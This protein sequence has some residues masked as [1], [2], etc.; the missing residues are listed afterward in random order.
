M[1]IALSEFWTRLVR[2]GVADTEDCKQI[3]AAYARSHGGS[4]PEDAVALA[5]FLVHEG[6]LSE[7]QARALLA[8][9]PREIRLG[10]FLKLGDQAPPPLS[11]WVPVRRRGDGAEGWLRRITPEQLVAADAAAI[12]ADASVEA[13]SLQPIQWQPEP[14]GGGLLFS[15]IPAGRVLSA[16]LA[17]HRRLKAERVIDIGI[18]LAEALAALHQ[19]GLVHGQLRADRVWFASQGRAVLLRDPSRRLLSGAEPG[20]LDD[21]EPETHYAAPEIGS[22]GQRHD[23]ATDLYGLGC[24]LFRLRCGRHAFDGRSA[25]EIQAAHRRDVPEELAGAVGQGPAGDPLLRV[26]ASALAKN[27]PARFAD[28]AQLADALRQAR[29]MLAAGGEST[30]EPAGGAGQADGPAAGAKGGAAVESDRQEAE[31]HAALPPSAANT[32]EA[33]G[34]TSPEPPSPAIKTE[35][36]AEEPAAAESR[37]AVP[38][39]LA[40]GAVA[41][42]PGTRSAPASTPQGSAAAAASSKQRPAAVRR[43]KKKSRAPLVL[44]ALCIP[45]LMLIILLIVGPGNSAPAPERP[46]PRRPAPRNLP[47]VAGASTAERDAAESAPRTAAPVEP[48]SSGGYEVVQ[49]DRLLWAPPYPPGEPAPTELLPPGPGVIVTTRLS[50]LRHT[51]TGQA[52]IDSLSPELAELFET[53]AERAGVPL[54]SIRRLSLALHPGDAGWPEVSLAVELADAVPLPDLLDRWQAAESRTPEGETIYAGDELGSDAYYVVPGDTRESDRGGEPGVSRFAVGSIDRISEVASGRGGPIPLPSSLQR[55]WDRSSDQADLVVLATPNFVVAD[56]RQVI[57]STAPE[58]VRPLRSLLIPDTAGVLLTATADQS[59]LYAELRLASSGTGSD[60][61]LLRSVRETIFAW[62][63]WANEFLVDSVPDP[64]WRLLATRLP[65]M[66]QFLAD[67]TRLGISDG[68]VVAN[69][70]APGP[71]ASQAALATLLAWNT[72]AEPAATLAADTARPLTIGEMLDREMSIH[73]GQESLEFAIDSIAE[74]FQRGLPDGSEMPPVRLLGSDLEKMGITQNQQIRDFAQS[75]APLRKVLTD[76]LVAANPDQSASGPSD[77]KQTLIW[78]VA[79]DPQSPQQKAIL[80]TTRKAA[81]GTYEVPDE[82]QS[83]G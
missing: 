52:M 44:G 38:E 17:N 24:L 69:A 49:D 28:A 78:V 73:F 7:Y 27:R 40:G 67:H 3:A 16:L 77:L 6:R 39:M 81:E 35:A 79:E 58:L 75:G 19:A 45:V 56:A 51:P 11:G 80:I 47:P 8:T 61:E 1:S 59:R 33:P 71:A 43:R 21:L 83:D 13:D 2:G 74:E 5:K 60:G 22:L 55:L 30:S 37:A 41:E 46:E 63:E 68:Q 15:P 72:P 64:S 62:P 9:P 23:A 70:Y 26:I 10:D 31:P 42:G 34:E 32:S 66:L 20:W 14:G 29:Q 65:M 57:A 54:D 25:E 4:P 48:T 12:E 18:A 53:A 82:F 76:L 50:R 36:A